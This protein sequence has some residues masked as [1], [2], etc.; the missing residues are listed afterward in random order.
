MHICTEFLIIGIQYIPELSKM[1]YVSHNTTSRVYRN[2]WRILKL[3]CSENITT[4]GDVSDMAVSWQT[5]S[6]V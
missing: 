5:K 3:D 2:D 4:E 1:H 6:E